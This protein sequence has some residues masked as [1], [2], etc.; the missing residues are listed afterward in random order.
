MVCDYNCR[1]TSK[2]TGSASCNKETALSQI[3]VRW[4]VMMEYQMGQVP[5]A[6]LAPSP[7]RA[8]NCMEENE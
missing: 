7:D 4:P 3:N 1:V 6:T 2:A 8:S 5:I